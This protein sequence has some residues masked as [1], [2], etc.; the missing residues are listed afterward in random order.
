[1]SDQVLPGRLIHPKAITVLGTYRCTAACE[2]CCFG[3]NPRLRERLELSDIL[4]FIDEATNGCPSIEMLVFSGGECFLLGNDLN[5]AVRHAAAKGLATRCVTNGFWAKNRS[6]GRQR[7]QAL[8]DAGLC[9]VN[10]STGD[11]HQ[12]W[13][14]EETVVNAVSLGVELGLRTVLM[15]ELVRGSRVTASGIV[16]RHSQI[17]DL[18]RNSDATGFEIIESPW[19][20]MNPYETIAQDS[21]RMVNRTNVHQRGGCKSIF[22]TLVVTPSSRIGFCC[23]LSREQIPELNADWDDE[24]ASLLHRAASDFLKIWIF[25]DG[26]ERIL[27]WAGAK[28]PHIDWEDRYSH[29]CH[30]C[31][32]LY[33]DPAVRDTIMKHYEERVEDVL[34]RYSILLRTQEVVEGAVYG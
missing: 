32:R 25:V 1:M 33:S 29:H 18:I 30:A 2:N 12:R 27:A 9:E 10:V 16:G 17:K 34:T 13:V 7:L 6:R 28:N 5:E 15:V 24:V 31:L 14:A 23:G 22:T 20:P 19:M 21:S 8:C 4:R 3:S 11:F 26:P